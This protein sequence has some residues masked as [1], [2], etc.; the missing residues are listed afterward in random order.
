MKKKLQSNT[1]KSKDFKE[2]IFLDEDSSFS[3]VPTFYT[4]KEARESVMGR[5]DKESINKAVKL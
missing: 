1:Q 5:E 2:P 3:P 4:T